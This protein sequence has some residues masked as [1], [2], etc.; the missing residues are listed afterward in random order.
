[1]IFTQYSEGFMKNT[2][3]IE[4]SYSPDEDNWLKLVGVRLRLFQHLTEEIDH[5]P[6][7]ACLITPCLRVII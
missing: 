6:I 4:W 1:M 7:S 2:V 5:L 3:C